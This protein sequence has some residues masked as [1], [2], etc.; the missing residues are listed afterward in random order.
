MKKLILIFCLNGLMS[1]CAYLNSV[2]LTSIPKERNQP[3]KASKE[4]L[5]ILGFNFDNDFVDEIN[6]DLQ[7]LCPDGK[8]TGILTKDETYSYFLAHKR[9]VTA[10]G[11]C[12]AHRK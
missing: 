6:E 4:R 7:R 9:I 10:T 2:S 3:I 5:I 12:V 1:S 8:A 11:Y